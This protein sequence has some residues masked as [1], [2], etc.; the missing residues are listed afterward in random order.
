MLGSDEVSTAL[1]VTNVVNN[2]AKLHS[3]QGSIQDPEFGQLSAVYN[4]WTELVD[5][6]FCIMLSELTHSPA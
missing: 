1:M 4:H 3:F 2:E 6:H 5:W